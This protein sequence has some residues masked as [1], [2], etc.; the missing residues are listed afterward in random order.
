MLRW[1]RC[2]KFR[3][4]AGRESLKRAR[5][6]LHTVGSH[7]L[8]A[9]AVRCRSP[10]RLSTPILPLSSL[11]A[12]S[13]RYCA[14]GGIIAHPGVDPLSSLPGVRPFIRNRLLISPAA[15]RVCGFD[16]CCGSVCRQIEAC[17]PQGPQLFDS[18]MA[19]DVEQRGRAKG[20]LTSDLQLAGNF[21]FKRTRRAGQAAERLRSKPR[22]HA[23]ASIPA[24]AGGPRD[25]PDY[26]SSWSLSF[27]R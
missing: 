10:P 22:T 19:T 25:G 24:D 11:V 2:L 27:M 23:S 6:R 8:F 13:S 1:R 14:V 18:T 7:F 12:T 26:S 21:E 9:V 4:D 15:I 3:Y 16:R 5:R 17:G 20:E